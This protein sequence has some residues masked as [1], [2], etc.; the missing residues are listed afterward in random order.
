MNRFPYRQLLAEDTQEVIQNLSQQMQVLRQEMTETD[1]EL[2]GLRLEERK[3]NE[4]RK[5]IESQVR[6]SRGK[7]YLSTC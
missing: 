1:T 5:Q 6:F 4:A 2:T 7:C 3:L